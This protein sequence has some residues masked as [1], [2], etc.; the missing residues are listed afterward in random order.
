[1]E[2]ARRALASRI[3]ARRRKIFI[4]D[5]VAGHVCMKAFW[6]IVRVP[7]DLRV[8]VRFSDDW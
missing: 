2:R 7:D 5:S 8:I 3:S 6:Q 1:L 4:V